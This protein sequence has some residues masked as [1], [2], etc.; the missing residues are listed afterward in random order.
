MTNEHTL[1]MQAR[2]GI[3]ICACGT[4]DCLDCGA[5]QRKKYGHTIRRQIY[6]ITSQTKCLR[7]IT[8]R[9]APPN[10]WKKKSP[11]TP[12]QIRL[13]DKALRDLAVLI[14]KKAGK[15][16]ESLKG[17]NARRIAKLQPGFLNS[18]IYVSVLECTKSE[19]PHV[20]IIVDS[21]AQDSELLT[22]AREW[23]SNSKVKFASLYSGIDVDESVW[24]DKFASE[25]LTKSWREPDEY[26]PDFIE[27]GFRRYSSSANTETE[28]DEPEF[29][30]TVR[31][32]KHRKRKSRC[33]DSEPSRI[34]TFNIE[35][36]D[37][38]CYPMSET[39]YFLIW[40]NQYAR[41][42]DGYTPTQPP[43]LTKQDAQR[44]FALRKQYGPLSPALVSAFRWIWNHREQFP[45]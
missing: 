10:K 14:R 15:L 13:R 30:I 32:S 34:R 26:P 27:S 11:N 45:Q 8:L 4:R 12:S 7:M 1:P 36:D 24:S 17:K 38:A 16:V 40:H 39:D 20:H 28:N 35:F 6:S 2:T 43:R 42:R 44:Q 31:K 9:C 41:K 33:G 29:R 21:S 37:G 22:L 3:A 5:G 18:D 19:L 25:Y 23:Q